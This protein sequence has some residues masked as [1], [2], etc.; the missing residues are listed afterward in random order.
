MPP[1]ID[2]GR[3]VIPNP[4]EWHGE[5]QI[6]DANYLVPQQTGFTVGGAPI[7]EQSHEHVIGRADPS[8]RPSFRIDRTGDWSDR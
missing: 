4:A 7:I 8:T 3:Y 2:N 6:L 5:G 1:F